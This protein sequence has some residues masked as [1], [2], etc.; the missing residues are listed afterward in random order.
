MSMTS[1]QY[2]ALAYDV[3]SAPKEV[4]PNSKPV[5]IGGAPY[6]RLA[7]VD[8]PSGY[9][10]I[11]YKRMDTGELVVAHRG[12]EFDSQM[13]RDGL[14]ADGG[15]VVTRHNAQVADA[16]EFTKH[17]LEYAEKIGKGSKVP[18]VTVTG[19]SLGGDLAQ[20]TAHHY[21][22]QGETFNAYGAVSLDRRIP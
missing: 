19:H 1:Q 14:A 18:H 11:L 12:T 4:G 8:R 9:Q 20:V 15:M 2:A 17:A 10:G 16:I 22:L 6:Q 7:Y 13:L 21:G 5:D 3:Y